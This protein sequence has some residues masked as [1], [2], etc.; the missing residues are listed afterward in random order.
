MGCE[1]AIEIRLQMT[2]KDLSLATLMTNIRDLDLD[3]DL[4]LTL[5][6]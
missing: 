3:L 2:T 1:V 4:D 5:Y 6:K